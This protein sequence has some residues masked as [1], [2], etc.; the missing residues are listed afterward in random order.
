M[1]TPNPAPKIYNWTLHEAIEQACAALPDPAFGDR[2]GIAREDL[3]SIQLAV[4]QGAAALG[5]LDGI[6]TLR[7]AINLLPKAWPEP[8]R[9][10]DDSLTESLL[11][12]QKA[13]IAHADARLLAEFPIEIGDMLH[14]GIHNTL[15]TDRPRPHETENYYFDSEGKHGPEKAR[16]YVSGQGLDTLI[17]YIKSEPDHVRDY[18]ETKDA[19]YNHGGDVRPSSFHILATWKILSDQAGVPL[20]REPVPATAPARPRMKP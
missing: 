8:G 17:R 18:F 14:I 10:P 15:R 5:E 4:E 11:A 9:R 12:T 6:K 2:Y 19:I 3:R 13:A 16:W 20:E 1:S 7:L